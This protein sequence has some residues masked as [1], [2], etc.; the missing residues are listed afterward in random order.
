M[1][2]QHH[3]PKVMRYQ[4]I[5]RSGLSV[6]QYNYLRD[7]RAFPIEQESAGPGFPVIYS[8]EAILI[9]I[10]HLQK[11]NLNHGSGRPKNNALVNHTGGIDLG[12][13]QHILDKS[14][15]SERGVEMSSTEKREEAN[16]SNRNRCCDNGVPSQANSTPTQD[17]PRF[18]QGRKRK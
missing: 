16:T 14:N 8:E 10:R 9:A 12:K 5:K 1:E 7:R 4:I 6:N 11:R 2:Q 15:D 13:M 18:G 3:K 17:S